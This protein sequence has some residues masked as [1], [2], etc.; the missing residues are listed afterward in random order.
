MHSNVLRAGIAVLAICQLVLGWG[1]YQ[2]L[3]WAEPI[4]PWPDTPLNYRFV[5][6]MLLSQG[7]TMA[8]TAWTMT[9]RASLGGLVGFT[10]TTAG[11]AAY[12]A[13]VA[14]RQVSPSPMLWV[15]VIV[16]GALAASTLLLAVHASHQPR[17]PHAATPA[18]VRASFLLFAIALTIA[19]VLL[20]GQ[21]PVVFPWKL[22]P[23][24]SVV[25]GLLF[26]ASAVY[27]LDG[28]LRPGSDN[29]PG[30]L[31]GFL[32]YDL[33]LLPP[34]IAH[35]AKATGGFRISLIIYL[36][37]LIWS[38]LLAVA[39]LGWRVRSS[40]RGRRSVAGVVEYRR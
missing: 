3:G 27:F 25:Y 22:S 29:A 8:W 2:R 5:G 39:Y 13:W 17:G 23:E 35:W 40:A 33:A 7:A 11:I 26:V 31:I 24:S 1:L 9:L 20:F 38:G 37:V 19:T 30:Q 4:W 16:C 12:M 14:V 32:V 6:A 28:W 21:A 36:V 34:W 10:M 18:V 15:W